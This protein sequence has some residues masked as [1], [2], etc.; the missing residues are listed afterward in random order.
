MQQS[1]PVT[2]QPNHNTATHPSCLM[3]AEPIISD[4]NVNSLSEFPCFVERYTKQ[5]FCLGLFVVVF[6]FVFLP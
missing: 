1:T 6:D 2:K 4:P 3:A 5:Y